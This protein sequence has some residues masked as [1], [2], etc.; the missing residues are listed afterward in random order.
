MTIGLVHILAGDVKKNHQRLDDM[1]RSL[2]E[3]LSIH[4]D[5]TNAHFD[6][7]QKQVDTVQTT[8]TQI[9][10]RLPEKPTA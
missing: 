7:L 2:Q 3:A 10:D 9:L 4:V 8:L 5:A 6:H 1:H